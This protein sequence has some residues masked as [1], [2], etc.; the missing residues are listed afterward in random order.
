MK[1]ESKPNYEEAMGRI[2]AWFQCEVLDRAPVRFSRHNVQYEGAAGLDTTR[3]GALKDRWFDSEHQVD[4]FLEGI[5]GQAFRAETFPV[6]W[7]NL[8]PDIYAAFFGTELSFGDITSWSKPLITDI[9][10]DSQI[11]AVKFDENN[12]YLLKIEEMTKLALEKCAGRAL[13]GVTC[14][15]P[16]IDSIAAW[17]GSEN[18]C[19]AL[20]TN[21]NKVRRLSDLAIQSFRPLADRFYSMLLEKAL[22]SVGWMEIPY[23]GVCHIAQTDFATMIS[24]DHF[25]EFCQPYL[26]QEITGMDK[27]IFHMD[28]K[29]VARHVDD[30]IAEAKIDAIQWVQG[31]GDDQPIMQWIPLIRKIQEG[32]KALVIDLQ[33][34]ELE[35]FMAEVPPEGILLCIP[36]ED[37][38]QDDIIEKLLKW[39]RAKS[40]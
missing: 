26:Q 2:S 22:P 1:L 31:V 38:V 15:C 7:P 9:E 12:E 36:A 17:L 37:N 6:F 4:S 5:E 14:W 18:L 21:P 10:D 27:V 39:S 3:W 33:L 30:L 24:P 20:V 40:C 13:V 16:G 19:M 34:D 8:G 25:R 28:G 32:G 29:G 11:A 23:A 35:P